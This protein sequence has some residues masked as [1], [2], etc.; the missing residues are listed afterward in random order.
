MRRALAAAVAVLAAACAARQSPATSN[1]QPTTS[2]VPVRAERAIDSL[3]EGF[4]RDAAMGHVEF[5]SRF[6]RLAGNDGFDQSID[7]IQ[8]RLLASGFADDRRGTPRA[9]FGEPTA[10]V[11]AYPNP[12]HGWD[13]AEGTLAIVKADG[14]ETPVLSKAQHRLALCINS[15]STPPGGRVLD[16]VD[17]GSGAKAEDFAGRDLT[18]AIVLGDASPSALWRHAMPLGAA[19]VVSTALPDYIV[20]VPPGAPVPPRDEWDIL[21]WSSI[22][23]DAE[24]RGFCFKASPRAAATLRRT[25]A[26]GDTR[27]R[28]TIDSS[29]TE[30]DA[31]MLIAEIPGTVEPDERI[32]IAAHVQE[33]GANDNASGSATLAELAVAM[34]A[35]IR[36]GSMPAPARTLTFLWIDEI[37]GSRQ[38]LK[39]F[40]EQA[41]QVRWMF[42]LDM[43]G[44]DLSKTGGSFLVERWPDPGAVY[45]REWDPH[46]EWGRGNVDPKALKGDLINDLHLAIARRVG[47]RTGWIVRSNPYEGGSDH[48]VFGSQG[49][50]S[51]LDWHFTDRY[52]HT[53]FD[54]PDK[55]SPDEMRNV[56]A[57]VGATAWLM[58]SS[59]EAEA[60]AV[61]RL[62]E[63][64]GRARIARERAETAEDRDAAV[65]AWIKWYEEAVASASRLAVTP[66]PRQAPS[67][68]VTREAVILAE[69]RRASGAGDY[70]L[71]L[72]AA[73]HRDPALRALGVRALGRLESHQSFPRAAGV[74]LDALADRDPRVRRTAAYALAQLASSR[75]DA[76]RSTVRTA[77]LTSLATEKE[78]VVAAAL[79][80]STARLADE[81]SAA[82]VEEAI[83][84]RAGEPGAG[85]ITSALEVLSR[86]AGDQAR[87]GER[88]RD[89]LRDAAVEESASPESRR[90]AVLALTASRAIDATLASELFASDDWQLRRLAL[91]AQPEQF[92]MRALED[93]DSHVRHE[94][95]RIYGRRFMKTP[96][97]A[98]I[99]A[100]VGDPDAHVALEAIDALAGCH[101]RAAADLIAPLAAV[102]GG[103]NWHRASHAIVSL[104]QVDPA[105]ARDLLPRHLADTA[106]PVRMYAARAATILQDDVSLVALT[107]DQ[108][109]NVREAA[110][111]GLRDRAARAVAVGFPPSRQAERRERLQRAVAAALLPG[112]DVRDPQLIRTAAG[113][114]AETSN[115]AAL[116]PVLLEALAAIDAEGAETTID[117]RVAIVEALK[118]AAPE[119]DIPD[120]PPARAF[121]TPSVEE[122]RSLPVRARIEMARGGA[123]EIEFLPEEA[124]AA[125]ARFARLARAGYYDGLT[126][127]RV[128][129]NFV[130]QGGSPWAN[131]HAGAPRFQRDELGF[132]RH[133]RGAVGIS[134]RGRDTGDAQIFIDL[135][136]LPRLNHEYTVFARV[137]S[138]GTS[139][140]G[141]V[142]GILEADVIRR[143][144]I[145]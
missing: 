121:E 50:P 69:D 46:S 128:V 41:K 11:H 63:T 97:C 76:G 101:E 99:L 74:L 120:P 95:V 111:L 139:G 141:T 66:A 47:N 19:G 127:H 62:V 110:I 98:P 116:A 42:S 10:R 30:R 18:N 112:D 87:L 129:P 13:H 68:R 91:L 2:L 113:A 51:L 144:T 55:V 12:G 20:P 93:V 81:S 29:F 107:G 78:D 40:P 122:L 24:R 54:T 79:M 60:D 7:R 8:Q 3:I 44:E 103:T 59:T 23:Y 72:A 136:D 125:V 36:D 94:A 115:P 130:V 118:A 134:T 90:A 100:A 92:V 17:V 64:A 123:F 119:M 84:A 114:V 65:A 137:V 70:A 143:V 106:W 109:P 58:A 34:R 28:V 45:D 102:P 56:A 6:W 126:F 4:D 86:R 5:M 38:W 35:A 25:L 53:N 117:A 85:G 67:A 96:G 15:F 82:G 57:A 131:E 33:P 88:A 49:I 71:L 83:L 37:S 104:A 75:D 73:A 138:A 39:D 140:M 31:R 14:T 9:R 21:Q 77:L 26:A 135:V 124:P 61:A 132:A 22:P 133:A 16:L 1:P 142:D 145:R 108:H 52:Y 43:T 105:R 32:V 89:W 80:E 27:A 48:T